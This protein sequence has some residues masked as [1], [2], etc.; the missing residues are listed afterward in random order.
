MSYGCSGLGQEEEVE[1][2]EG[3]GEENLSGRAEQGGLRRSVAAVL[4]V[5][6]NPAKLKAIGGRLMAALSDS[7]ISDSFFQRLA[8]MPF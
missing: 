1:G 5:G 3:S 4:E 8:G 6:G 7:I 2:S